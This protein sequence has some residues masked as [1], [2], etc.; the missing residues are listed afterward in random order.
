MSDRAMLLEGL[1]PKSDPLAGVTADEVGPEIAAA[2]GLQRVIER[3]TAELLETCKQWVRRYV[4]VSDEQAVILAAWIL[5]TWTFEAA[6]TTPYIHITAPERECGKS[7]LMETLAALAF[8]PVRSGGMTAAALVRCIDAKSPTIFLDEMDAQLNGDKEYAEAIRGI[9]NEGFRKGGKFYKVDGKNHD[10]REFNA[11]CPKCFAGIGKLPET[12]SSR[13]IPIEMRRKT[14]TETVK[15]LRQRETQVSAQ[16]IR[17]RLEAWKARGVVRHLQECR[18]AAI[19]SLGDR[20]NDISEPLLAIAEVAGGD[21]VRRLTSALV[22]VLKGSRGEN[23]STG[24]TLLMDIRSIFQERKAEKIF[25]KELAAALCEIEGRLWADWN[26]GKGFQANDLAK[27]LA[28]YDIRPRKISIAT[29]K[30]Q[31]YFLDAFED[32]WKRYCPAPPDSA[33]TPELSASLLAES[34]SGTVPGSASGDS[35]KYRSNPHEQRK[36]PAV[37]AVPALREQGEL[38]L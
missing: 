14:D 38:R 36:V 6:E 12:V 26:R 20:Q 7:R 17:E 25:S 33:G 13:S 31:G 18:P 28:R 29:D 37:P 35:D 1:F 11:Y 3:D 24:V 22:T 23:V 5:H 32:A 9:L 21:W 15:P 30:L 16:P 4:I 34:G 10:L 27:Q 19:D 2:L 8:A